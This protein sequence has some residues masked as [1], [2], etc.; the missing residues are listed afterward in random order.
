MQVR[1]GISTQ[2]YGNFGLAMASS[3]SGTRT[4]EA[5]TK[6]IEPPAPVTEPPAGRPS[7]APPRSAARIRASRTAP[8]NTLSN[9]DRHASSVVVA[10]VPDGDPPTL[11]SAPS[12]RPNRSLAAA[13]SRP[14]CPDRRYPR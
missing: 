5:S 7:P 1:T 9:A 3:A 6:T 4:D 11:I 10:T 13:I 14:G 12:R 8:R 2:S